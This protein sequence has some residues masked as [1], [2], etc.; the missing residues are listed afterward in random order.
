MNLELIRQNYL[1]E[2]ANLRGKLNGS[3]VVDTK[4]RR[5]EQRLSDLETRL[6][7]R[8]EARLAVLRARPA[9]E[10]RTLTPLTVTA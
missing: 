10:N 1:A 6:I 5:R 9:V 2:R 7:P 8:V 3:G 4:R